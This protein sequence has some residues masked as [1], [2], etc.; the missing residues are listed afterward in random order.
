MAKKKKEVELKEVSRTE[1]NGAIIIKYE[2]GSVKIIP[3]PIMLSAEEAEDLF[4]SESDDEEEE[5]EEESD[6]DDDDSEEEEE[7]ESDDDDEEDDDDDDDDSEE[8]EE[9]EELTGE[10]LAE[11]DFEELEDVCDDKD[12]ETDPDDYDEDDIEKLRKAIAKELGLK[13]PAKKEAKGK[14]KKGKK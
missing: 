12:L 8:E 10:E 2:D 14:D 4:G 3:A 6:D 7:E 1:I 13:L 11:M 5:E 9:E